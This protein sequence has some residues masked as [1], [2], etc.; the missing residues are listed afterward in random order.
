M[1][2][3]TASLVGVAGGKRVDASFLGQEIDL[4]HRHTRGDGH[5]LDDVPQLALVR[6]GRGGIDQAPAQHRGDRAAALGQL[7]RLEPA[8]QGNDGQRADGGPEE[9]LRIPERQLRLLAVNMVMARADAGKDPQHRGINRQDQ[10]G[11][12]E[13]EIDDQQLG[14]AA[15]LVLTLEEVHVPNSYMVT[16][17]QVTAQLPSDSTMSGNN[18]A[19]QVN[20]TLG[21]SF[22]SGFS[23]TK[24]S[25]GPK[26]N[27]AGNH[28]GR[29]R[30]ALRVV[31]HHRVVVGLPGEG[32]LVLGRGELLHQ[33][34]HRRVG[35]QVG[36]GLGDR[37]E[38]AQRAGQGGFRAGQLFHRRGVAGVLGG[39][40]VGGG[41][42]V[43]RG[44]RRLRACRAR[45]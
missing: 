8:A 23:M 18:A 12:A 21:A 33:G 15:G 1:T 7:Q 19:I 39:A 26:L 25:A 41:G 28:V 5:F 37:E 4:R 32:D 9:E 30:L 38:P 36:I 43:A 45:A 11:D 3:T 14:V 20:E 42:G 6:V 31:G 13:N 2:A 27:G 17:L 34:H 10:H 40:H 35:L 24:S 16:S 44:D 29:E 22:S